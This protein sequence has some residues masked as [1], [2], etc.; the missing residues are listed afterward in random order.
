M[1]LAYLKSCISNE[2]L[3]A[4]DHKSLKMDKEVDGL[5]DYVATY[6]MLVLD[7]VESR[8]LWK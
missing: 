5:A 2:I 3:I 1:I 8:K 7:M 4:L 6:V